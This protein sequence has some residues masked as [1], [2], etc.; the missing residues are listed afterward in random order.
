M[1]SGENRSKFILHKSV[2]LMC[3]SNCADSAMK[4]VW[5]KEKTVHLYAIIIM[6]HHNHGISHRAFPAF[7]P[8]SERTFHV[9]LQGVDTQGIAARIYPFHFG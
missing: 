2:D 1:S 6:A 5:G 4:I 7:S 3:V 8:C 9:R